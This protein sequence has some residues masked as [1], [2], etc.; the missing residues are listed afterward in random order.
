MSKRMIIMHFDV[1]NQAYQAVSEI[2]KWQTEQKIVGDQ[3]AIVTHAQDG[4]HRFIINKFVDF[5]FND[6]NQSINDSLIH[7]FID[8]L[9]GPSGILFE[10][11]S[12]SL[13]GTNLKMKKDSVF[14]QMT[15]QLK[16]GETGII[17]IAVEN[18]NRLLNYLVVDQLDGK[19]IRLNLDKVEQEINQAKQLG[20]NSFRQNLFKSKE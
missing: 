13:L 16:K 5:Y 6:Q 2:K 1:N 3:L 19:I 20:K 11:F 9:D 10:W 8:I 7:V 18:D 12:G 17:L 4:I 14:K 15:E